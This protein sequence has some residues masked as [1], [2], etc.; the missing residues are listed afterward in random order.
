M[1]AI[2]T[3]RQRRHHPHR[4]KRQGAVEMR[5][6][7][8]ALGEALHWEPASGGRRPG[9]F[10]HLYGALPLSAVRMVAPLPLGADGAHVF[11]A[12]LG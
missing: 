8:A 10:P 11:P 6:Q 1:G 12:E 3:E 9:L 4:R 7:A 2:G 5:E